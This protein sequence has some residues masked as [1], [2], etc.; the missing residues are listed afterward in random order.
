MTT[1]EPLVQ[2]L[3]I[4]KDDLPVWMRRAMRGNDWGAL[5]TIGFSVLVAWYFVLNSDLP[6][7]NMTE[8][9]AFQVADYAEAIEEGRVY[10]RWAAHAQGGFGAPIYHYYPPGAPYL[11][12]LIA[13][14]FALDVRVAV[15]VVFVIGVMLA[16][17]GTYGIVVRHR[18]APAAVLA[19]MLY[20]TS[21][22]VGLTVPHILGDMALVLALGLLPV[23]FWSVDRLVSANYPQDFAFVTLTAAALI[24]TEPRV[25][26]AGVILGGVLVGWHLTRRDERQRYPGLVLL[27]ILLGAVLVSFYWLPAVV[28]LSAVRWEQHI[29]TTRPLFLTWGGLLSRF[30]QVDPAALLPETQLSL[31]WLRLAVAALSLVGVVRV[32]RHLTVEALF[33]GAGALVTAAALLLMP[34]QVWLLGPISLCVAVASGAALALRQR[35]GEQVQRLILAIALLLILGVSH[36][37]WL[38]PA[39]QNRILSITPA[40]QVNHERNDYGVAVVPRGYYPTTL[41]TGW[42][43]DSD[44][45]YSYRDGNVS[46]VP[47]AAL[48]A[49]LRVSPLTEGTHAARFQVAAR[50]QSSLNLALAYFPG[51]RAQI[52]GRDLRVAPAPDAQITQVTIPQTA[53]STLT[54]WLGATQARQVAWGTSA[55][56]LTVLFLISRR[57][58]VQAVPQFHEVPLL[59]IPEARLILTLFVFALAIVLLVARY[60]APISI[61]VPAGSELRGVE[62]LDLYTD[63]GINLL[64]YELNR[65]TFQPGDTLLLNL[66]WLALQELTENYRVQIELYGINSQTTLSK[67]QIRYPGGVPPTRWT[68]NQYVNDLHYIRITESAPPGRYLL[69]VSLRQ[70]DLGESQPRC[71]PDL[72]PVFFAPDGVSE[73]ILFELPV[74]VTITE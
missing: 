52:N 47:R 71:S 66:Y 37:A 8:S 17:V 27:A 69:T 44:L 20:V 39:P 57:R 72:R 28:E 58:Y 15:R 50:Q 23:L 45:L 67:P 53:N 10:P 14:A 49:D 33:L 40:D 22:Y 62:P 65:T 18:G 60:E 73:G 9:Y 74:E 35:F 48:S 38:P 26:A 64:G 43:L 51:W 63:R 25:A 12:G 41:P 59:T 6:R 7:Y 46:R 2:D 24:V 54:V 56:A 36:P 16:G 11:G 29:Q 21:P 3:P 32:Q 13:A 1:Q 5:L 30:H 70:C 55:F 4:T 34:A 31:G 61:R 42:M 68:R 19:A